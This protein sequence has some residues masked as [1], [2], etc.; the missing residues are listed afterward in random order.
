MATTCRT[1]DSALWKNSNAAD[2]E[3]AQ[4]AHDE[5]PESLMKIDTKEKQ[6]AQKLKTRIEPGGQHKRYL[7]PLYLMILE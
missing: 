6:S 1:A 4:T 5:L 2:P 3:E 7:T